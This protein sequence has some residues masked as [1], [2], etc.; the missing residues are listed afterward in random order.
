MRLLQASATALGLLLLTGCAA[1][2]RTPPPVATIGETGGES[3]PAAARRP[4]EVTDLLERSASLFA[5]RPDSSAVDQARDLALA[6]ARAD[7]SRV[8]G[9]LAAI[10]SG[11]WL[12]E[13]AADGGRRATLATEGVQLAQW[14]RERAPERIECDYRLALALGQQARERP[15]TAADALPRLTALLGRV[16]AGDPG[17]DHAGGH[18]VLALVLLRAPAWPIGP[19]DPEQGLAHAREA[20]RLYPNFPPN[21]LALAEALTAAGETGEALQVAARA[22]AVARQRLAAG[23]PDAGE[24][25]EQARHAGAARR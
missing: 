23:D 11:A 18:R 6:A 8:E 13:H 17:L 20:V 2:L 16:V 22:E 10:V 12:I 5:R 3:L 21:L 1:S 24:W 7:E 4:G 9:L 15:A 19:G 25:V 14:C